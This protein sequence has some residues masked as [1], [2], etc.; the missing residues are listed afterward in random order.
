MGR[1]PILLAHAVVCCL[2]VSFSC[3][4]D[5][6]EEPQPSKLPQAA[7]LIPDAPAPQPTATPVPANE[8]LGDLPAVPGGGGD[9]AGASGTCG[10]PTP[11]AL[12]RFSVNVHGGNGE[13]VLLD[14]TPLVGPDIEYCRT[15]GFTDGRAFC[16]VRPEGSSEREACEAALVGSAADTGRPGPTWSVDGRRCDGT[17]T[18]SGCV[19]HPDNQYLVYAYGA[20]VFRACAANGACGQITLP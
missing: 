12:A 16:A 20:G 9:A 5:T 6:G 8:P 14:A 4:G 18:T 3:G 17:G 10:A 1:R 11:P 19:N 7:S 13:R 2:L 15:I